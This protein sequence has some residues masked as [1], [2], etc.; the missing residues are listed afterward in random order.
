MRPGAKKSRCPA[1]SRRAAAGWRR[2]PGEPG[3]G[4]ELGCRA[5]GGRLATGPLKGRLRRVPAGGLLLTAPSAAYR[6]AGCC[7]P[8]PPPRTGPAGTGARR[9]LTARQR[10]GGRPPG[11]AAPA[12]AVPPFVG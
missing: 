5:G 10:Y 8:L 7:S 1:K 6:P 9:R 3:H 11:R 2:F 4:T 12:R